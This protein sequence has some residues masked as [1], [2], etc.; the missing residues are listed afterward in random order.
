MTMKMK[1]AGGGGGGCL[2][3]DL[4]KSLS[5]ITDWNVLLA[6]AICH[7]NNS[8]EGGGGQGGWKSSSKGNNPLYHE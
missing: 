2:Q 5:I 6:L 8:S 3:T 4:K 7:S 1:E